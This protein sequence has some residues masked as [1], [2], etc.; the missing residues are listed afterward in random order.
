MNLF[1]LCKR[2]F[3]GDFY[4]Y[5]GKAIIELDGKIHLQ[6]LEYDKLNEVDL[7]EMGFKIIRFKK[8]EVLSYWIEVCEVLLREIS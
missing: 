3:I 1:L 8:A 5:N 2:F 4:C 7:I 6:Q